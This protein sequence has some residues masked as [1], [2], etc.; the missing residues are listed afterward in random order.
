MGV[1][2]GHEVGYCIRFEDFTSDRTVL[3]YMTGQYALLVG[4]ISCPHT[5]CSTGNACAC[6]QPW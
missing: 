4:G 2:L 6:T 1:K 5:P 3:K